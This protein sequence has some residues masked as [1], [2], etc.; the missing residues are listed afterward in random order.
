MPILGTIASSRLTTEPIS[1]S[2]DSIATVYLSSGSQSS[3]TFSSIP[4]TYKHLQIRCIA[5]NT[6]I[7]GDSIAIRYNG[8]TTDANYPRV[9]FL[10]GNGNPTPGLVQAASDTNAYVGWSAP[11]SGTYGMANLYTANVF[12][13]LDYTNTSKSKVIRVVYGSDPNANSNAFY[14]VSLVS[15]LSTVT[16][17]I[18][19]I[20]VSAGNS[21]AQFSHF[22]LY[23]IK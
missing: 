7:F 3:F 21:F 22:A 23:G 18:T 14:P 8:D 6:G 13:I 1:D 11:A 9:H 12:E 16:N 4:Q 17:A 15:G 10:Y 2:F 5:K 19:S 20:T